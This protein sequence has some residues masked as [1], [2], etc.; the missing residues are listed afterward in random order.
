MP[1]LI[2]TAERF[3]LSQSKKKYGCPISGS[4]GMSDSIASLDLGEVVF[5]QDV[6]TFEIYADPLLEKVFYNLIDNA[7]R[8]GEHV[9]AIT[10]SAGLWGDGALSITVEDDGIGL[11]ISEKERIFEWGE[12]EKNGMGTLSGQGDP[13]DQ[14]DDIAGDRGLREWGT[15]RDSGLFRSDPH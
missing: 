14:S 6:G 4:V 1:T 10:V 7:L 13:L 5:T 11:P 12:G 3:S 2:R 8:H 15:V 9:T